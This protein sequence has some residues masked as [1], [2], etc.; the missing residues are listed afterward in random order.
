MQSTLRNYQYLVLIIIIWGSSFAMMH[1]CLVGGHFSPEQTV[2]YRLAIGSIVLLMA[3]IFCKKSFPKTL[4]PW[5]HFFIYAII[6]NIVPFLLI[7]RGQMHIT[8]GM[9]GLLMA[10]VPLVTMVLAHIFLPNNALN[11]FKIIGFVLGISGVLFILAPSINDGGSTLFGILLIL[12]AAAS[13]AC[14]GVVVEKLPKY[15]PIV[16]AT[17]SSILACLLAFL[18]WPDMVYINLDGV[19]LKTSLNMLALG[20]LPSALG[21]LIFFNLINNA[22]ATFLSNMNYVIPVYAFTLGALLLGEPV[23]WQNISALVL[24]VFGI[25]ISRRRVKG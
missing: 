20:I 12:G 13:Y 3:C 15:D 21:A 9:T 10:F 8:S 17:C 6:G 23:L 18:I 7:S 14:H 16:A 24:I 19:P 4:T 1:E 5:M 22:G 2:G 25:F 11:R